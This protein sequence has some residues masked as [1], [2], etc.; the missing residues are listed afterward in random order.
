MPFSS[1]RKIDNFH[2]ALACALLWKQ[3]TRWPTQEEDLALMRRIGAR[4]IE[5]RAQ[6][7]AAAEASLLFLRILLRR[8]VCPY[9]AQQRTLLV[10]L[11][12]EV[13][14]RQNNTPP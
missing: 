1:P 8:G 13:V 3:Q 14:L 11:A 2:K 7:K 4:H 10:R 6:Q 12:L 9:V 5:K